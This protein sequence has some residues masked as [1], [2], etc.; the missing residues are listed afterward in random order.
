[1]LWPVE[2]LLIQRFTWLTI[3][4]PNWASLRSQPPIWAWWPLET[5]GG[6]KE[7]RR[8]RRCSWGL[9]PR[10]PR[11]T[12]PGHPW[13]LSAGSGWCSPQNLTW[14]PLKRSSL[15]QEEG[16]EISVWCCVSDKYRTVTIS[17]TAGRF[18][19]WGT[20]RLNACSHWSLDL[21]R[22]KT[23]GHRRVWGFSHKHVEKI[24]GKQ[25]VN[26]FF[27]TELLYAAQRGSQFMAVFHNCVN[28]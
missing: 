5:A 8:W 10:R 25:I 14:S 6:T 3:W 11:E 15:P 18:Y 9:P 4:T 16:R 23:P 17:N 19:T 24:A 20:H 2:K 27:V 12:N 26:S 21:A 1:M 22:N 28:K 7:G 13:S